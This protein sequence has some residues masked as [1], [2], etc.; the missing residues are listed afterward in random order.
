MED[1][2]G[3]IKVGKRR[4]WACVAFCVMLVII[5]TAGSQ[6]AL[7]GLI[8]TKKK[9]APVAV[10][11]SLLIFP[12]DKDVESAQGVPDEFGE[13]LAGYLRTALAGSKGYSAL[14]Y[15]TRL[16]PV[17]RAIVDTYIREQDAKVPFFGEKQK[18]A[19][20]ANLFAT[21]YYIVG[22]VESYTYDKAKKTVELTL[23]ADLVQADSGKMIQ[24]FLVAA[25][26][27]DGNQADEEDELRSLAAGKAV[28]ALT[29]K[30][31]GTSP[32]DVKAKTAEKPAKK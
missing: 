30:I 4:I 23:K 15:D 9:D 11:Q 7:F 8:K 18:V 32:A 6:A 17:K 31:L 2:I 14:L 28:T 10:K 26:A 22:S 16:M 12:F 5:L 3:M 27:G 21:D 29:E 25:T 20:L 13:N 1:F 24:E 19:K